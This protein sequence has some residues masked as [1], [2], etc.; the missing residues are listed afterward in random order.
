MSDRARFVI[1]STFGHDQARNQVHGAAGDR[2][3]VAAAH[4]AA[5]LPQGLDMRGQ[6]GA[7]R[8]AATDDTAVQAG[9]FGVAA[10]EQ[11][12]RYGQVKTGMGA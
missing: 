10:V 2:R 5:L 11:A 4:I 12:A 3:D 1:A 6:Q 8:R 9:H 7:G